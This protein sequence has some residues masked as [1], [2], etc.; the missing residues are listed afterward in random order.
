MA[1]LTGDHPALRDDAL[2]RGRALLPQSQVRMLLPARIGDFTDF[3]ASEHHAANVGRMFRPD[4]PL[5]PNWKHLPV[6]YH[7]RA[8]SVVV[9]GTDVIRPRG[10]ILMPGADQPIFAPTR[11]LDFELEMGVFTGPGNPL[12][13]SIPIRDAPDHIFGL[14]L[15]ND[16]SAR[17]IQRWEYRPLGPFLSKSFAT[18]LSPWVVPLDALEPFRVPALR[19]E[20]GP[21]PYLQSE[22]DWAYDIRLEV[23]LQTARMAEPVRISSTNSRWLYWTFPQM[24]AHQTSNGANVRPGDLYGSGTISGPTEDSRGSLLELCWQGTKPLRLPTGE[25]RTFVEDGD[26]VTFRAGCQ[27]DGYRVGFGELRGA[28]LP[29]RE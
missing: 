20:P 5:L 23:W 10:Q 21:L 14:V 8:S 25:T 29:A 15:L 22:G 18:S 12:G 4:N 7:G 28:I 17:D 26:A 24:L 9:S 16:W 1:L 27:G 3:Y 2:L 11:E 13:A 6:G 19:Q